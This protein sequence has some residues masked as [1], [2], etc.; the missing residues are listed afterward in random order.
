MLMFNKLC[1]PGIWHWGIS[2]KYRLS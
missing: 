1:Y 2:K